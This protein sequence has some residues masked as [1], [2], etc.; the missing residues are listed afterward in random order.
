LNVT[1]LTSVAR[2]HSASPAASCGCSTRTM[3][4]A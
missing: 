3:N 4:S 1:L 2:G